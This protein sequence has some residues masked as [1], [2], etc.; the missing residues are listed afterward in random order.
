METLS[1]GLEDNPFQ[2]THIGMDC[3]KIRLAIAS[4]NA[5]KSGGARIVTWVKIIEEMVVLLTIYDKSE[6][7]SIDTSELIELMESFEDE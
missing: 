3:Y 2:G 6:Q 4:K 5:G 7:D 1:L